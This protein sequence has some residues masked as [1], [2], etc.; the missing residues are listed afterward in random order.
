MFR[1]VIYFASAIMPLGIYSETITTSM[2][3]EN[4]DTGMLSAVLQLGQIQNSVNA[5]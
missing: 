1:Y 4:L 5:Q 3:S 2:C